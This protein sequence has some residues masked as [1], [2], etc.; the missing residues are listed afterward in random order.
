MNKSYADDSIIA[1]SVGI[2]LT[3]LISKDYN[4]QN[5]RFLFKKKS[6]KNLKNLKEY[7]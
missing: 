5:S 3:H 4:L 2:L 7:F 1:I 6:L